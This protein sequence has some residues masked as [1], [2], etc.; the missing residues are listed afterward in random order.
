M[1]DRPL[2]ILHLRT[3]RGTGGGPDKTILKSCEYLSR[4][5]HVCHAYYM[6]D[7][8]S[9]T[10]QLQKLAAELGVRLFV[11]YETGPISPGVLSN[12]SSLLGRQ[13]YDIV[14]THEYKSNAVA[15]LLRMRHR[16]RIVATAH[17]YNRTTTREYFYYALEQCL[18]RHVQAI[19]A[20][21]RD[22]ADFL[23]AKRIRRERIQI[24][25]NGIEVTGRARPL[26][27]PS[28]G[29]VR[30][31]YLGRL[32][33]EKDPANMLEAVALLRLRGLDVRAT[34]AGDG[35]ERTALE[36][37]RQRLGLEDVVCLAGFVPDVMRL[38]A[39]ADI[40][41]N[42]SRTECMPNAVL[43][44]MWA[45]VPVCATDV[46]GL[47]EMIRPGTDGLLCRPSDPNALADAISELAANETS[48]AAIASRL[49][50]ELHDL[51][52]LCE[53]IEDY[54]NNETRFLIISQTRPKPTGNDKTSLLM[55]TAHKPGALVAA[56]DA[57]RQ[58]GINLTYIDSRPNKKQNWEYNFFIDAV[59]HAD[60]P[61][62]KAA[63]AAAKEHTTQLILLG[64]YPQ[65][66][67]I[68]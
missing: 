13:R 54:A 31:L 1:S 45:G 19:I 28:A 4:A 21:T 5:G 18:F 46:G 43:E 33:K 17:G 9:D 23:A 63:L 11:G 14:H 24:I 58:S 62:M 22:M 49:A 52:I 53:N 57:F 64:S 26:H 65:A 12:L 3:V 2:R 44:A 34:L 56:L 20:P 15:R 16:Y 32:S 6:L 37:L 25:S 36:S 8:E 50:A 66:V 55:T 51:K 27:I 68:L 35:P 38:L 60:Q 67:D 42:P 47:G 39:A 30:L 7:R 59:G 10:G 61:D 29:P 41:V 48:S 40:L